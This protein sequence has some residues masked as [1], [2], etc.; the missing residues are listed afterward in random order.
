MYP[1]VGNNSSEGRIIVTVKHIFFCKY[2]W[3]GNSS[4]EGHI[5]VTGKHILHTGNVSLILDSKNR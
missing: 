5:I 4:S 3:M 2:L 1:W